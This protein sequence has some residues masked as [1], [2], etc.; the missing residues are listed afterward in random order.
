MGEREPDG[1]RELDVRFDPATSTGS[2]GSCVS[3][4]AV[5]PAG[6]GGPW[7]I[8]AVTGPCI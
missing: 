6:E 7:Y 4:V 5:R 8:T 1:G 3:R 2:A